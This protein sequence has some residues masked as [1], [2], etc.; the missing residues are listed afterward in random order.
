MKLYDSY[1][2]P[3]P[4]RVRWVMAEKG[5]TDVEIVPV[6]ILAGEHRTPE[7]RA[8]VGVAHVPALELDDGT[9][10]SESIAICRYLEALH[11]EPNLF[12]RDPKEQAEI[13]MWTRRAEI[14][15]ANPMMLTV[16]HSHPALAAL[17][18]QQSPDV[19]GFNRG[20]AERFMK[21]LDRHLEEREFIAADRVTMA[22]IVGVVGLDFARLIKYRPPEELANLNRWY[23]AMRARPAAAAG[24]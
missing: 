10:I 9:C 7:Y 4:R 16:R 5:I 14:Y 21:M 15:F 17:E 24:A 3:N 22:D 19:A 2:A 20:S 13:E 8:K 23:E 12:G 1:R 11:P 18:P 6:D